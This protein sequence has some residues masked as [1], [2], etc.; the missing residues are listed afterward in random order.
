MPGSQLYHIRIHAWLTIIPYQNTC[1]THNYTTEYMPDSELYHSIHAR[2]T[3][4]PQ[5]TCLAHNYTLAEYMPGSQLYHR[6]HA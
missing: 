5:N 6:I 2:L 1:L 3:I 4:I